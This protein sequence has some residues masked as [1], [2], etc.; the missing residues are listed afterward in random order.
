MAKRSPPKSRKSR[1][2]WLGCAFVPILISLPLFLAGVGEL[3]SFDLASRS[4]PGVVPNEA[5]VVTLDET[6]YEPELNAG[7]KYPDFNR[8]THAHFLDKLK[9]DGA[10]IVVFDIL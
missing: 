5:V 2:E 8:A 6:A 10:P 7:F 1:L 9:E 3:L 4:G